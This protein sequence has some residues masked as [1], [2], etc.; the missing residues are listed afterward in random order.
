MDGRLRAFSRR[1]KWTDTIL[2]QLRKNGRTAG[3]KKA[4]FTPNSRRGTMFRKRKNSIVWSS[5]PTLQAK[6]CTWGIPEA[7][8]RLIWSPER[9][10][11]K[12]GM[13]FIRWV[14]MPL[15][16]RR[17]TT[18]LS[19]RSTPR[20]SRREISPVLRVKCRLWASALTGHV[21]STP[22]TPIITAGRSGYSYNFSSTGWRTKRKC[23]S[24]GAPPA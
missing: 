13:S 17:R 10:V 16:C 11:W 14:G 19:T 18:R 15:V 1:I 6:A 20:S 7:I 5:F 4:F 23:P 9:S 24:T 22:P 8:R 21:K 12:A 2:P 3:K